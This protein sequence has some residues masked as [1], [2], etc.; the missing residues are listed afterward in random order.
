MERD[1]RMQQEGYNS[2]M[3][4][5]MVPMP[6]SGQLPMSMAYMP[7]QSP[8]IVQPAFPYNINAIAGGNL[9][10]LQPALAK[11]AGTVPTL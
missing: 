1:Y 7:S 2:G 3:S 5:A 8:G 9:A 10:S 11:P 4:M 6:M